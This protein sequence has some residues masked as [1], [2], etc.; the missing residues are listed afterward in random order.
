MIIYVIF[1]DSFDMNNLE[2]SEYEELALSAGNLAQYK[3]Q[4]ISNINLY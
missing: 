1:K 2:I 4:N 3:F